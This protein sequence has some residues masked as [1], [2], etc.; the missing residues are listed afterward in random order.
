MPSNDIF[1][2]L[3]RRREK[4]HAR[5][6]DIRRIEQDKDAPADVR[7]RNFLFSAL[8]PSRVRLIGRRRRISLDP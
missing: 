3:E 1:S 6:E 4:Q 2:V 8:D 7:D 5:E